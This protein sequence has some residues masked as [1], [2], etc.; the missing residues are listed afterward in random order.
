MSDLLIILTMA[1]D[2]PF[3]IADKETVELEA[4]KLSPIQARIDEAKAE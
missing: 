2:I 1:D 4:N 3:V